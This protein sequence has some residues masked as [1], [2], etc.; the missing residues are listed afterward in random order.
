MDI[1]AQLRAPFAPEDIEWRVGQ[2]TRDHTKVSA[3][4]YLTSRAVQQRLDD[5]FGPFGWA[6][7]YVKGPDGG[8]V[9]ELSCKGP[10]GEWVTKADGATNTDFEAVKGGLSSALKRAAVHWGVGRYLYDLPM[11]WCPLKP[12]GQVY[13]RSKSGKT[14]Y[15]DPPKLPAW[16]LPKGDSK[17]LP[18]EP[19]E[20]DDAMQE[21][22]DAISYAQ[23]VEQLLNLAKDLA[24]LDVSDMVKGPL[25][26]LYTDRMIALKEKNNGE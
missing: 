3:L 14:M 11:V 23:S 18:S 2:E 5:V 4:A 17:P 25:R 22:R 6:T 26:K 7:K 16:A 24:S 15:W 20:D 13:H 12:K 1:M 8:V 9:C 10:D 19:K 21:W